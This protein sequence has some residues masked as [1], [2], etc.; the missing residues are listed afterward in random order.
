VDLRGL[1]RSIDKLLGFEPYKVISF[2]RSLSYEVAADVFRTH[3]SPCDG[4]STTFTSRCGELE[5]KYYERSM[6]NQSGNFP[7]WLPRFGKNQAGISAALIMQQLNRLR[8]KR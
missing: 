2:S 8:S 3:K 5:W 4:T 6:A 7:R 1:A